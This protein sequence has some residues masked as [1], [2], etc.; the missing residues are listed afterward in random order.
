MEGT[1]M[2]A[3]KTRDELFQSIADTIGWGATADDVEGFIEQM[4]A[5]GIRL[6]PRDPDKAMIAAAGGA[7]KIGIAQ[8]ITAAIDVNPFAPPKVAV[9]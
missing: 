5:Q 8:A 4:E 2:S 6:V 7:Q 3:P 1:Q 9:S